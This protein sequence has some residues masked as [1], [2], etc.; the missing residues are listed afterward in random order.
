M[1][2]ESSASGNIDTALNFLL[3]IL[4]SFTWFKLALTNNLVLKE[5]LLLPGHQRHLDDNGNC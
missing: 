4:T 5:S 2:D 3:S 1:S